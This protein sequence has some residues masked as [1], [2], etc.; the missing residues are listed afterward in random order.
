MICEKH[1]VLL[2]EWNPSDQG[3]CVVDYCTS[4][5]DLV[6]KETCGECIFCREGIWQIYEIMNSITSGN[7]VSEDYE[8]LLDVLEQI[9]QGASCEMTREAA[10]RCIHLMKDYEEE[11][12]KHIRRKRCTNLVCRC[13]YTL[14][15][16]P[17]LC[18]GCGECMAKCP[19]ETIAGGSGMIHVIQQDSSGISRLSESVCPKGIIRRAGAR[20]P[21]LPAEPVPAGSFAAAES[22]DGGGTARRRRRRG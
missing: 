22:E 21:K 14:Y 20:K 6:R 11:W 1:S 17:Q 15:I 13:S 19:A 12:D 16:D 2:P 5:M 3:G 18:D 4:L 7:A 9:G 10:N 8:L